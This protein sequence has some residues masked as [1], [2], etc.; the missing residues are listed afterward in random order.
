M[1]LRSYYWD[2]LHL[3]VDLR[4]IIFIITHCITI[5][6]NTIEVCSG[7]ILKP[8]PEPTFP[9]Q[10]TCINSLIS[11]S[12]LGGGSSHPLSLFHRQLLPAHGIG[13]AATTGPSP[14]AHC[15]LDTLRVVERE[16][17]SLVD[18]HATQCTRRAARCWWLTGAGHS[19]FAM[20]NPEVG[21]D[22]QR[23]PNLSMRG[24]VWVFF[25]QAWPAPVVGSQRVWVRLLGSSILSVKLVPK[26]WTLKNKLG[27]LASLQHGAQDGCIYRIH[28]SRC[29]LSN[30]DFI[31]LFPFP[32][33]FPKATAFFA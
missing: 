31:F 10:Q 28:H 19:S 23:W 32:F 21:G 17:M 27:L 24:L 14:H 13:L 12:Q 1:I 26:Y 5:V 6:V 30:G 8:N 25:P 22:N 3:T 29:S 33:P 18:T 2:I 16:A 20:P 7:L 15:C 9:H 4:K 11:D